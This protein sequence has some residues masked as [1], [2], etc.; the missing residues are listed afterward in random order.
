MKKFTTSLL[1]IFVLLALIP[2]SCGDS[3]ET[4]ETTS[5][6]IY[7]DDAAFESALEGAYFNLFGIYDGISGGEL[8]GGDFSLIAT[9]LARQNLQE[10]TWDE[11]N[12]PGYENFLEKE[13]LA[14]N[15]IVE[16]NWTRAYETINTVNNILESIQNVSDANLR[17][18][19]EGEALAIRGI[20]Y[21][22]MVRLWGPQY[23]SAT[24]SSASI[25]L[26]LTP[27]NSVQDIQAP[28]L[29]TVQQVYNQ[30]EDDLSNASTA[31]ASLGTNDD[32]ISYYACEAYLARV[33]MQ[34]QDYST[35]E[36]HLNNVMSGPFSLGN[37]PLD[38]F[39][40]SQNSSEDI[41]AVQQT[42]ASNTGSLASL[43]GLATFYTSLPSTGL[44][45]LRVTDLALGSGR[46]S[47][48]SNGPYYT[49]ADVRGSIDETT[50][51]GTIADQVTTAFYR[52][53][54]NTQTVSSSK[55]LRSTDVLP[56][57]RLSEMLLSRAEAIIELE[58]FSPINAIAL[59]DLN[60]VRIRAGLPALLDTLSASQ[61]YDSLALER[62]RELLFEGIILHDLKR[63]AAAGIDVSIAFFEDPLDEQFILPI[64]Q[65]ECDASPGLCSN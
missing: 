45:T 23:R 50:S 12:V 36:G 62:N 14:T 17:N 7:N 18:R 27:I 10:I 47:F 31:L 3:L 13:V 8:L 30:V 53:P 28:T 39:N 34:K 51:E 5:G 41:L 9:L 61:F 43:S 1:F 55:Y 19:I 60:A 26:V 21:F 37:S 52:D 22:E 16:T 49:S 29:A 59:A 56:V 2:Y 46:N 38:A 6:D 4:V 35:A 42:V 44:A 65:A 11:T 32:R 40:N 64:P 58:F 54:V 33:A 25:P 15:A 20:L 57:I 63:R 24:L 48:L